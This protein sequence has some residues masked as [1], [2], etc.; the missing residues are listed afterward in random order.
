MVESMLENIKMIKNKVTEYLNGQIKENIKD[1]GKM[2][3]NMEKG[4]NLFLTNL[5][6]YFLNMRLFKNKIFYNILICFL[7][8]IK[9]YIS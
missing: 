7:K 6:Y 2:E 3:N 1:I 9:I 5:I 4:L 8:I